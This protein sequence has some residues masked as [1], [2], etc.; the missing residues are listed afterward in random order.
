MEADILFRAES[1]GQASGRLGAMVRQVLGRRSRLLAGGRTV[2]GASIQM[3]TAAEGWHDSQTN[4][5]GDP[6]RICHHFGGSVVGR[7]CLY[8]GMPIDLVKTRDAESTDPKEVSQILYLK[9]S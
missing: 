5:A 7:Q 8:Q 1:Y 4:L 6:L 9:L 3:V 2:G